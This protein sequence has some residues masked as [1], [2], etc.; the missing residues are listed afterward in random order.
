MKEN[1]KNL[2]GKEQQNPNNRKM[3]LWRSH[4][5]RTDDRYCKQRLND[6]HIHKYNEIPSDISKFRAVHERL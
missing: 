6:L 2:P 1:E 3:Q 5:E 4:S